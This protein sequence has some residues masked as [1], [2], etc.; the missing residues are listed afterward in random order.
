MEP[1]PTFLRS[2][3]PGEKRQKSKQIVRATCSIQGVYC[4]NGEA[5]PFTPT[6]GIKRWEAQRRWQL[7][8]LNN[9]NKNCY[10]TNNQ[11][12]T[13]KVS[14]HFN[15]LALNTHNGPIM[16]G[17][18]KKKIVIFAKSSN[19]NNNNT[20][21]WLRFCHFKRMYCAFNLIK[22]NSL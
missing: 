1:G 10:H 14:V 4:K 17:L 21:S 2:P 18:I 19:N 22:W 20:K 8:S 5:S 6:E 3:L 15:L 12:H 9:E 13:Q 7:N 16:S 11:T